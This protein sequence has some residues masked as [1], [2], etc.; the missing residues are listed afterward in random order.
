MW[1]Q[2]DRS[3]KVNVYIIDIKLH[4]FKLVCM[5]T[6]LY[7]SS[8]SWCFIEGNWNIIVTSK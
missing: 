1:E 4:K 6:N 3:H 7:N 8:P 5:N 2:I